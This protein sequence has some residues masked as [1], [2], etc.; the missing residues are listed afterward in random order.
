[1]PLGL[2]NTV[3]EGKSQSRK[4]RIIVKNWTFYYYYYLGE[5]AEVEIGF[6]PTKTNIKSK[7]NE[8]I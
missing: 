7:P 1:M 5:N 3:E 6:G 8:Y 2:L 4:I